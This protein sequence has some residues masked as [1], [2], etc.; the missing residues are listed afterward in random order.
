MIWKILYIYIYLHISN[1][2]YIYKTNVLCTPCVKKQRLS[3]A[4]FR[5]NVKSELNIRQL[6]F[7]NGGHIFF[8]CRIF[9]NMGCETKHVCFLSCFVFELQAPA[10]DGS[11]PRKVD[12]R[13]VMSVR[14]WC[15]DIRIVVPMSY[16]KLW[17][18]KNMI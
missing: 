13:A 5:C 6:F 12:S 10:I 8:G 16:F 9:Q 4:Q 7:L 2:K 14:L 17:N 3:N 11:F 15:S 1:E 18:Y